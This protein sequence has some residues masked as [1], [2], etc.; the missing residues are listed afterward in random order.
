MP[1][2][3][4]REFGRASRR[5]SGRRPPTV[6]TFALE[7]AVNDPTAPKLY[8]NAGSKHRDHPNRVLHR[9]ADVALWRPHGFLFAAFPLG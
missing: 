5:T 2:G 3:V 1:A 7:A 6:L 9:T 4:G 8:G